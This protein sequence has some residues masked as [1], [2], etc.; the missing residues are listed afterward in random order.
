MYL[1]GASGHA[2]V[3][4]DILKSKG[5][6]VTGIFDD[7]LLIK[8]L[9]EFSV[10]GKYDP[11]IVKNDKIIVSIGD[12]KI[13]SSVTEKISSDY[14]VAIHKTA[15]VSEYS[16]INEGTVVMHN[17]VVQSS[18][19]IGKHV[20]INTSAIV[21]HDCVVEDFVHISPNATLC[22]NVKI[23][24]G[25]HVGAGATIIPGIKVGKWSIIGAGSV[26][27]EDVPDNVVIV[28]NPGKII[29]NLK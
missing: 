25:T 20:I 22:G 26:I 21:E 13:R 23:G 14:G 16:S 2:K 28:G 9:L 24:K 12:N 10:I 29:N 3:I 27:I 11:G 7:N 19:V 15:C 18:V 5:I 8:K 4:I 17:V 1:Y 6:S